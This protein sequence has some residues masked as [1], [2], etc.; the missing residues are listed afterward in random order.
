MSPSHFIIIFTNPL[1]YVE[2]FF[3]TIFPFT[4]SLLSGWCREEEEV[5]KSISTALTI[6]QVDREKELINESS[7]FIFFLLMWYN[8]LSPLSVYHRQQQ[9]LKHEENNY[10]RFGA[11]EICHYTASHFSHRFV[12]GGRIELKWRKKTWNT[13]DESSGARLDERQKSNQHRERDKI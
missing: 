6:P 5:K 7:H 4:H 3:L 8:N 11:N 1:K 2:S 12:R 13:I 10:N 9:Q